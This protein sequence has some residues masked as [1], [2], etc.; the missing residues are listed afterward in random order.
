VRGVSLSHADRVVFAAEGL[1]KLDLARYHDEVAEWEMP[2]LQGR[3]LTLL[4]CGGEISEGCMFMK[5]SK[6][7]SPPALRRVRI[8]EK[9]KLG[10][11]LVADTPEA[12]LSLVQMDAIEIHTWNTRDRAVELPDRIVV[13]LDPGP[14]VGWRA[15]VEAA[16]RMRSAL[17][18]L[19][20]QS[21]VKTTGGN[22]LHVVAPIQPERDWSECLAFARDLAEA[23]VRQDPKLFTVRNPKAG[24]ERHILLDYLRN[25]RTNT[26]VA[27]YSPRARPG[28]P[29]S[30][31]ID[32]DELT[33]KLNPLAFTVRTVPERL[34][35]MRRDPWKK[36]WTL[37]Q[38]LTEEAIAAVNNT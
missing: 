10:E 13:D 34:R 7:W 38:R 16:L 4:R 30:L 6:L 36:L 17:K 14:L 32:W 15:V 12:L 26:S 35:S 19:G 1:T 21:F 29:V 3:P 2:H 8:Q 20:L 31:P 37:R 33:V 18:A 5:H 23:F 28:A 11:Y 25:N 24:R 27:A 22:G 9:H